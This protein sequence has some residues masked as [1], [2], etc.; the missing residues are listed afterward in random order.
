MLKDR[1]WRKN[2]RPTPNRVCIGTD[3]NRNYDFHWEKTCRNPSKLTYGGEKPFSE[4]E[5][6]AVKDIMESLKPNCKMYL[7]LHS[8]AQ[9]F[10]YPWG[11]T[12]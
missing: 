4:P 10:L 9:A 1:F 5:T 7:S 8:Y 11:C 2:R 3:C 12:K 6:I